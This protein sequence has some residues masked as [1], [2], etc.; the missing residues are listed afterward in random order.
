MAT[1]RLERMA[2]FYCTPCDIQLNSK[3][4]WDQHV[5]G[6]KHMRAVKMNQSS[7][8]DLSATG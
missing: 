3:S 7:A 5:I 4:Q 2:E 1:N 8:V 6:G